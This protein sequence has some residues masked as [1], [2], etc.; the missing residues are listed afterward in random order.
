MSPR[1]L[2]L[3]PP[4]DSSG[5]IV[6][7]GFTVLVAVLVGVYLLIRFRRHLKIIGAA[8]LVVLAVVA[9]FTGV[10]YSEATISYWFVL[11]QTTATQ[12]NPLTI[13]CE[14]TGLLTGTFDLQLSFTNA[15]FSLK[16]S[17]P[18]QL[19]NE[20]TVMFTFT[21]KPGEQQ[22]RT[23][24]FIIDDNVTDFYLYLSFQ[25]NNGN[26]LVRASPG[27]VDTV[28]YQKDVADENFTMR[29]F[30]PPP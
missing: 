7:V 6:L 25:Q 17:L 8:T 2:I 21:L 30:A 13:Y 9:A 15:H 29:T 16:T 18:Y 20:R 4:P 24:W 11:A 12:D 10:W 5:L 14:N 28:S 19:L 22:N 26:F 1:L 27:G 3:S 23:A